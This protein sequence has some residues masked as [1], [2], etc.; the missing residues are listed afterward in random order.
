MSHAVVSRRVIVKPSKRGHIRAA[1]SPEARADAAAST[2]IEETATTRAYVKPRG[3]SPPPPLTPTTVAA[4]VDDYY[5]YRAR[6]STTKPT[7]P[8]LPFAI[9]IG[10]LACLCLCAFLF[11]PRERAPVYARLDNV[12]W[13]F[14]GQVCAYRT[15][16]D[17]GWSLPSGARTVDSRAMQRT[18]REVVDRVEPHCWPIEQPVKVL[19]HHETSCFQQRVGWTEPREVYNHTE[20]VCY[21][22]G[23]CEE[24]DVYTKT[25]RQPR[26]EEQCQFVPIYR[27]EWQTVDQCEQRTVWRTEPV[28]GTWWTFDVERCQHVKTV[29][30]AS[31]RGH[32]LADVDHAIA[33]TNQTYE[34]RRW[35]YYL[36]FGGNITETVAVSA[37]VYAVYRLRVGEIVLVP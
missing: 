37:S 24:K 21:A 31:Q 36:H 26:Y 12:S 13:T 14:E 7:M 35:D 30:L 11:A 27:T 17:E 16:R 2:R 1:H 33:G 20:E 19:S 34:S 5:P 4:N 8:L 6:Y 25:E 28:I 3:F 32:V 22:N 23:L 18:T 15:V 10:A 29:H 9:I